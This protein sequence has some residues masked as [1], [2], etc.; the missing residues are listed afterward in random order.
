MIK[1]VAYL[2][3]WFFQSHIL[4]KK[5][6]LQTVLLITDY[7]NLR[8]KHCT[9]TGHSCVSSKSYEQIKAELIYSYQQGSRFVDFEGGEPTLWGD[10][11]KTLNDLYRLAKEIGFFSCTLTTNGQGPFGDTLA[12][13]VWVSV[14]GYGVYHDEIR[15]AG[16]FEKLDKNIRA[17]GHPALSI[18]MAVN[19]LNRPSLTDAA[20]YAKENPAI[21]SIA[22]NLHTPFPDT[23]ELMMDWE[24]R[25]A[26]IDEI[27]SLKRKGYPIMNTVSGLNTMKRR[28]FHKYCWIA[29]YILLDGTPLPQCPGKLLG[30][31]DDC[32]FCMS[33]EMY[34]V[35][36]LRPDT[37][38]AGMSLR[39]K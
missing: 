36:H 12:D 35:L 37:L 13:S 23:E 21:K 28:G 19:R 2:P 11:K 17:S 9:P 38:L 3:W 7:C 15:G 27:I 26:V 5:R 4:K 29:N 30:I 14:D 6:P 8:C 1:Q 10:G 39:L 34:S 18:A 24:E 32:G 31:C 22:F 33:G 25:C 20:R 16:T